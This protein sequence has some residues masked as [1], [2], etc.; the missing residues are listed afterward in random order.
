MQNFTLLRQYRPQCKFLTTLEG[1]YT[2]AGTIGKMGKRKRH[3]AQG[4]EEIPPQA[5]EAKKKKLLHQEGATSMTIQVIVGTYEKVLHGITASIKSQAKDHDEQN[6]V[7]FADTFLLNAH[8]SAIRC[9]A[10]RMFQSNPFSNQIIVQK[11]FLCASCTRL[12][13]RALTREAKLTP[14]RA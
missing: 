13:A 10:V 4:E 8:T 12:I 6:S 2:P 9:L 7:E 5:G 1:G 14:K 11:L 3:A